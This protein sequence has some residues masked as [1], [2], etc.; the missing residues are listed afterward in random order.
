MERKLVIVVKENVR[1]HL[2]SEIV[3]SGFSSIEVVGVLEDIKF[4]I[5]MQNKRSDIPS[6][7]NQKAEQRIEELIDEN[8]DSAPAEQ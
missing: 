1:G 7:T 2:E 6:T 8:K 3:G 5:M 4:D